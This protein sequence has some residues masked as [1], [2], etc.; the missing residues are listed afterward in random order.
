MPT[1]EMIINQASTILNSIMHQATGQTAGA[2]TNT[3]DFVSVATT[4]LKNGFDPV[5]DAIN[6]VLSKTILSIRPYT[7]KFKG[8]EMDSARFG[9][10][11]RKLAIA[12]RDFTDDDAWKWPVGYDADNDNPT[13]DGESVDQQK[14]RKSEVLQTNF[15]GVNVYEDAYTIFDRQLEVALSSPEELVAF[16]NMITQNMVDKFEQSREALARATLV[17]FMGGIIDENNS[18]R[19]VH[20]LTEYKAVCGLSSLTDKTVWQPANLPGF[21]KWLYARIGEISQKM[22][23]R[24]EMFQTVVH[25]KHVMRHTPINRQKIYLL[26]TYENQIR[27][28]VLADTYHDNYLNFGDHE[29]VGYWQTIKAP[30][31]INVTCSRI[32]STGNVT[33]ASAAVNKTAV[34]GVLFDEDAAGYSVINHSIKPAPYNARGEYQNFWLHETQKCFNDHTEKGVVLLMD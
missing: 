29:S 9:N 13:G 20:L 19:V 5:Y 22:S 8:L 7:R 2:L 15:Y 24:S 32:A 10:H 21:V 26:S 6:Q 33:T 17:N 25:D 4:V 27:A 16:T 3:A 18:D 12:D 34:L 11:V 28:G 1:N 14:I 31:T 30:G 23:E